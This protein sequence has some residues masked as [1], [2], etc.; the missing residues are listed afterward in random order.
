M[1]DKERK[2]EGVKKVAKLEGK[3]EIESKGE[4]RE[5][6]EI[7]G[8]EREREREIRRKSENEKRVTL[9]AWNKSVSF[10]FS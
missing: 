5:K 6:K 3:S 4:E 10:K 1:D 8:K 2:A 7:E 9:P